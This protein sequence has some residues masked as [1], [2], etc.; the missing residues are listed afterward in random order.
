M[1]Y[2]AQQNLIVRFGETELIQLTDPANAAAIDTTV[3]NKAIADADA[4]INKYLTAYPL[5][6]TRVPADFER[7]ACDITRY[8]LYGSTV[9]DYVKDRFDKATKYLELVAKGTI[10]IAPDISGAVAETSSDNV[11]FH[12]SPSVFSRE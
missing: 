1:A 10:N 6:L 9:P 5:P 7:M 2:C 8:F 12:S 11:E 3:L 4:E